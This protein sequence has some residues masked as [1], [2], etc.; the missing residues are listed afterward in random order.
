MKIDAVV[1]TGAPDAVARFPNHGRRPVDGRHPIAALR[2]VF[3]V[4]SGTTSEVEHVRAGRC[5]LLE[6]TKR[7]LTHVA[8]RAVARIRAVV[9]RRHPI[10]RATGLQER[11]V[12]HRAHRACSAHAH[13]AFLQPAFSEQTQRWQTGLLATVSDLRKDD[14]FRLTIVSSGSSRTLPIGSWKKHGRTRPS[15]S[16]T[17]DTH[18]ALHVTGG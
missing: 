4:C 5:M 9:G 14:R 16:I 8:Q 12:T 13:G 6:Q 17:T 2:E 7:A 18:G 10:E 1:D 15:A 11:V 3:I